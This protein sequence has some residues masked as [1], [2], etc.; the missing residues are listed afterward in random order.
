[1]EST[2]CTE[3]TEWLLPTGQRQLAGGMIPPIT[4]PDF[5]LDQTQLTA[6]VG[7]TVALRFENTHNAPHSFDV[8]ELNVHVPAAPGQ[9]SLI[10]FKPTKP[11]AYTFYCA[12]PG[13][14]EL[15]MEGTLVVEP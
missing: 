11:G 3:A 13:H 9:Q 2:V 4:T 12:V 15:G 5:K 14:R 8:D 10:L 1:M 6:K 7:E